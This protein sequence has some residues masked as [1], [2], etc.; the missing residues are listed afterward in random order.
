V[1][2][3]VFLRRRNHGP[4]VVSWL[5][6]FAAL[7]E[8]GVQVLGQDVQIVVSSKGGD[9]LTPKTSLRFGPAANPKGVT[10]RINEKV[11]YQTMVGFGASFL[12]AGMICLNSLEAAGQESVL[13]ALFD[14][15]SGAGFT[16][17]KTVIAGT[18]FMSAGPWYTYDDTPGDVDLKHFSIAR[19]LG[20]NGLIPYIKLARQYGQFVLQAPMD[21]PPDWMLFDVTRNQDVDPRYFEVLAHYYLRYLR[22]Y[23]ENGVFVDYLSLF[24]EP[25]VYTKIPY[26]KIR[27]LLKNHVGP[28]LRREGIKTQLQ[29]S[30]APERDDAYGHYPTLLDDAEARKYVAA[31]PYHGYGFK[32][33]DKIAELHQRYQDLPIWMTEVCYAYE[34]G[35]P[36]SMVLPRI[37]FEDGDFWGNQIISDL[38]AHSSAWIYWNMILD[39]KG[40]PWLVSPI[41]GNPDPNEQ[42]PVVIIDRHTK[43]VTYTGLYYYLAHF[44]KFVRPG[45]VRI[46]VTG[47]QEGVRCVAFRSIDG[48]L[49]AQVM[50]SRQVATD[51]QLNWQN[52]ALTVR[53]PPVSITTCLWK[54]Q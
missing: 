13:Q 11:A 41:H 23:Q 38:E 19:D 6:L 3:V 30:E 48:E 15:R 31:V 28:L 51:A 52:R 45:A 8:S 4:T 22:A 1:F 21:Y 29:L 20:P 32:D 34:A 18:D 46:E 14:P 47:Q 27:D 2:R 37:D 33:Y 53:L 40:G 49:I 43:K 25:G 9:R 12:E 10:F 17:M 35:T 36:R 54:T 7:L 42:H 39:E 5:I 44:S 24:N 16:A 50:N 26:D